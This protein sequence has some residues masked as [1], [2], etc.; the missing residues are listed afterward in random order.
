MLLLC[1]IPTRAHDRSMQ[2]PLGWL[3][4]SADSAMLMCISVFLIK[5]KYD[6]QDPTDSLPWEGQGAGAGPSTAGG[7][8]L[9][10]WGNA[11]GGATAGASGGRERSGNAEITP[12]EVLT[13]TLPN[14]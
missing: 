2:Q 8:A 5:V 12:L 14:S 9:Q 3:L 11:G 7:S 6:M 1:D 10:P 4:H 13:P